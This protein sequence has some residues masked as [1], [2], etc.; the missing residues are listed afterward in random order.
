MELNQIQSSA[1]NWGEAASSLNQNFS[2]IGT[3]M[4]KMKYATT[5]NKGYFSSGDALKA[6]VESANLG[7]IAYVKTEG[8]DPYEVWEWAS[9]GWVGTGVAGGD[10]SID[11]GDYYNKV[12]VDTKFENHKVKMATDEV[13]GGIIAAE[14][15]DT[16]VT[17]VKIDPETG[18]LYTPGVTVGGDITPDEEDLT[19]HLEEGKAVV[20]FRDRL[21]S[22]G[23]GYV[24][25]REGTKLAE[26]MTQEN[27]IY[28]IRY[29]FD[30]GGETLEMPSNSVLDF[31]GG[32][33]FN[34]TLK[35]DNTLIKGY[36]N[37][38][39]GENLNIQGTFAND[40]AKT[41]WFEDSDGCVDAC[42]VISKHVEISDSR[43]YGTANLQDGCV[44]D[45]NG[46]DAVFDLI[47]TYGDYVNIDLAGGSIGST[48]GGGLVAETV[49]GGRTFKAQ[50]GHSFRVGQRL[51][52]SKNV[53][54]KTLNFFGNAN[55][56]LA[57]PVVVTSVNGNTI[58]I[59]KD[60]GSYTLHKGLGL[61]N[62][63]WQRFIETY[64]KK[65]VV[66]NGVIKNIY[67]Y[68]CQTLSDGIVEFNYIDFKNLGLDS[69]YLGHYATLSFYKCNISKPIDYAKSTIMLYQ[70]SV[71]VDKC[72]VAGGN[73]DHFV[74]CWRGDYEGD[75][76]VEKGVIKI[77]NTAFDG[78]KYDNDVSVQNNLHCICIEKNGVLNEVTI[79]NCTFKGYARHILSSTVIKTEYGLKIE[80]ININ[81]VNLDGI[82]FVMF[83]MNSFAYDNFIVRECSFKNVGESMYFF[84]ISPVSDVY[85]KFIDCS[86]ENIKYMS[87]KITF[88]DYCDFKNCSFS[89]LTIFRETR[90]HIYTD[91]S[92]YN[93][94][95]Y[96]GTT[97]T[98]SA[99][100][101]G[102]VFTG[103]TFTNISSVINVSINFVHSI[104]IRKCV[105]N[106]CAT[107][108]S[109]HRGT[110][111]SNLFLIDCIVQG[112]NTYVLEAIG[113]IMSL[114]INGLYRETSDGFSSNQFVTNGGNVYKFLNID[115]LADIVHP[116][117]A[118]EE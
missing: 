108:L 6:A 105:F 98:T 95:L 88:R 2:K 14:R 44:L 61:G 30:L 52:S 7:D 20:R 94:G 73:F 82:P 64:G 63:N 10:E 42:Q 117:P 25:L 8:F 109:I 72:N 12:D 19:V 87:D 67:A 96:Y 56:P 21:P 89:N 70:G 111:I 33:F 62:T 74:G 102:D 51:H 118:T 104:F 1:L 35:G 91:C 22:R 79:D 90:K 116:T 17:E 15:E 28:E 3:D 101:Y 48:F 50:G 39:F 45:V 68:V 60:L 29:D 49:T 18:R 84:Y 100:V 69:F 97:S 71:L 81:K 99:K 75:D 115:G 107:I 112:N 26:Q 77:T 65:L 31:I 46:Q 57:D 4:E 23:K 27:T 103:C 106:N 66:S 85:I 41:A 58:T 5:R 43:N 59:N 24:I 76:T 55:A 93:V 53:G 13:L 110:N 80:K 114:K 37:A 113:Y 38:V 92:F 36:D 78:T 9:S 40:S 47:R 34:G 16:D 86:F 83:W 32:S 11:L 54:A